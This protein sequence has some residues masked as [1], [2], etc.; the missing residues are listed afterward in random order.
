MF[1]RVSGLKPRQNLGPEISTAQFSQTFRSYQF[2]NFSRLK[3]YLVS[4]DSHSPVGIDD[5]D[6]SFPVRGAI[7]SYLRY[8]ADQRFAAD[9]PGFWFKLVNSNVTGLNNLYEV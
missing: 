7:W 1:Y 4:P 5:N 6:D 3:Q 8:M 9:E 2:N